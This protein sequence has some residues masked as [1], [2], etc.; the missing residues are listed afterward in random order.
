MS[1]EFLQEVKAKE[2]KNLSME[3]LKKI[4]NDETKVKM[5]RNLVGR[6]DLLD[7]FKASIKR[8]QNNLLTTAE[9]IEEILAIAREIRDADGWTDKLKL[10]EWNVAPGRNEITIIHFADPPCFHRIR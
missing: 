6:N 8:C 7:M 5:K 9:I 10:R 4:F 2:N 1:E 3:F